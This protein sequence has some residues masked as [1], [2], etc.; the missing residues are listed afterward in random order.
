MSHQSCGTAPP[1]I[2]FLQILFLRSSNV[3]MLPSSSH[4]IKGTEHHHDIILDVVLDLTKVVQA[5]F[6][7]YKVTL[8]PPT[9]HTIHFGSKL[10]YAPETNGLG[11]YASAL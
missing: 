10:L 9:V 3:T 11:N 2:D 4:H 8:F 6:L 5:R 1:F 7:Y